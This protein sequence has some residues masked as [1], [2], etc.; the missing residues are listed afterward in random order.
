MLTPS[1]V[2]EV[3]RPSFGYFHKANRSMAMSVL[4]ALSSLSQWQ[5]LPSP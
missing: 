2:G 4:E 3:L 5:T 1:K